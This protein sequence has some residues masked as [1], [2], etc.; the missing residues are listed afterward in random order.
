MKAQQ[1]CNERK[2]RE[3]KDPVLRGGGGDSS[4]H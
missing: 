2:E 1:M 4:L 3:S